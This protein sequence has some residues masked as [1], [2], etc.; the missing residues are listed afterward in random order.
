MAFIGIGE[1]RQKMTEILHRIEQNGEA[2]VI[3]QRQGHPIALLSPLDQKK[4]QTKILHSTL[5]SIPD[6]WQE[7]TRLANE[8]RR[9]W[10]KELSTQSLLD[11]TRR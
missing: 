11:I 6:G 10:P 8:L 3:T 4:I 1:L 5:Q 7:Y 9:K 2:Y